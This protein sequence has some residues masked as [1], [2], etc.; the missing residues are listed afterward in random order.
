VLATL[1]LSGALPACSSTQLPAAS[2]VLSARDKT[3]LAVT[4]AGQALPV[5]QAEVDRLIAAGMLTPADADKVKS[6]LV[7]ADTVLVIA[8]AWL[9]GKGDAP[10]R[11]EV[12]AAL[13]AAELAVSLT[14]AGGG[15][16]PAIVDK[17]IELA[18]LVVE[19]RAA[20]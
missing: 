2:Q 13:D 3:E 10:G 16:L 6:A 9:A 1:A 20:K 4:L 8:E 7:K 14:R 11:D 5:V 15:K 12:L 18:R 19:E 17:A